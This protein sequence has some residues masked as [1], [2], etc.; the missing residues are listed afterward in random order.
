MHIPKL[1]III[2]NMGMIAAPPTGLAGSLFSQVQ[3]RV[4]HLLLGH[5][6]RSFHAAEIIR[7]VNSGSG[8]V[9]RELERL[10]AAG[11][12]LTTSSGNR[13]LYQA[14]RQSPIFPEL[15]GIIVKTVGL[16]EP[17]RE[18]LRPCILTIDFAFV[19]G[20]IAKGTDTANSDIDLMV[21][22]DDLS[23]AAIYAALERAEKNL[24]RTIN[25]TAMTVGEWK[26]KR[27]AKNSFVLNVLKQ[28]RIFV[29]GTDD[30]LEGTG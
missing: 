9:Q 26:R 5:P 14:N 17:L 30:E 25:P 23:Y 3:L 1:G 20:S 7:L 15:H 8:A 21:L 10:T 13:K 11:I 12:L 28:P 6:E 18:A 22:G 29:F 24:M 4:L 19:Y 16:L 2:P 27:K